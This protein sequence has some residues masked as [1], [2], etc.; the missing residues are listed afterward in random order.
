[1]VFKGG[2][3][4]IVFNISWDYVKN[5]NFQALPNNA[6]ITNLGRARIGGLKSPGHSNA[7]FNLKTESG[8][9]GFIFFSSDRNLD[10]V[11]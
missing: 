3:Q 9:V 11:I 5:A 8:L 10:W 1:M 7:Q 2:S 4:G 6:K